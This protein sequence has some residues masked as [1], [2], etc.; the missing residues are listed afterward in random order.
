[1]P[2]AIIC[3]VDKDGRVYPLGVHYDHLTG[4]ASLAISRGAGKRTFTKTYAS[5]QAQTVL[6]NPPSTQKVC[7]ASVYVCGTGT[8]GVVELNFLTSLI[9]VFRHY[10]TKYNTSFGSDMHIEGAANENL[11]LTTTTGTDAVFLIVNYR[12]VS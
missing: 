1:M 7:V 10:M 3:G 9:A 6:V 2:S 5:N 4:L 12:L 11:T 8:T